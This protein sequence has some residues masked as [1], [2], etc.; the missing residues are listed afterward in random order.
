MKRNQIA[1]VLVGSL[2][3][4]LSSAYAR[5]FD[6]PHDGPGF[7]GPRPQFYDVMPPGYKTVVAAGGTY[8]VIANLW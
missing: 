7:G 3:L 8:F 2:L 4:P 5:G 1:L 6:G